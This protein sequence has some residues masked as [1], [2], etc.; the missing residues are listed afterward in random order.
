VGESP[1]KTKFVLCFTVTDQEFQRKPNRFAGR[2]PLHTAIFRRADS[3]QKAKCALN[4]NFKILYFIKA[5][6]SAIFFGQLICSH[7]QKSENI[8]D[9]NRKW[10]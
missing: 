10:S 1:I 6:S 3:S 2:M 4:A 7:W 5:E 8:F 9:E